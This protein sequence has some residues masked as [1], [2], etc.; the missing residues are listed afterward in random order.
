MYPP[1]HVAI[2]VKQLCQSM[3]VRPDMQGHWYKHCMFYLLYGTL[4]VS[5]SMKRISVLNTDGHVFS[6]YTLHCMNC[7]EPQ[8][9]LREH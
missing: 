2:E 7:K 3:K 9:R 6:V 8:G 4:T 1:G 5:W